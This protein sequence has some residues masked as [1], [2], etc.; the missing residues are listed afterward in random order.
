LTGTVVLAG[1][2]KLPPPTLTVTKGPPL[3]LKS[4]AGGPERQILNLHLIHACP[5]HAD[6]VE[7]NGVVGS[8]TEKTDLSSTR[9]GA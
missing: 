8:Q 7:S 9:A 5:G 6:M 1:T 3:T 4:S 2:L